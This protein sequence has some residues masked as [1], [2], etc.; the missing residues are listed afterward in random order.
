VRTWDS[1]PKPNIV[2]IAS[3]GIPFFGQIYTKNYQFQRF[4]GCKPTF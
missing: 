1:L 2:K 3:G 4:W